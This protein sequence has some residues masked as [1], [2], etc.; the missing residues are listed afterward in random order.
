MND[1]GHKK[2]NPGG[3]RED[4]SDRLTGLPGMR[5]LFDYANALLQENRD[6]PNFRAAFVYI[7][8]I[9]FKHYNGKYGFEQGDELIRETAEILKDCFPKDLVAHSDADHFGLVSTAED[10][11]ERL[12]AAHDRIR[13]IRREDP[14][15]MKAGI[16]FTGGSREPDAASAASDHARTACDII[17]DDASLFVQVYSGQVA[18]Q[19]ARQTYIEEHIDSAIERGDIRVYYQPIVRALTGKLRGFEA[20]ARW[21]DPKYGF[22]SPADFIP[23]LEKSHQ[24][25]KLDYYVVDQTCR[26]LQKEYEA[27]REIVPVSFNLSRLDFILTDPFVE[28]EKIV[29]AHGLQRDM[30][31]VELTESTIIS[32]HDWMKEELG[33]FHEAGYYIW[34]DDFGSGYSALNV[35]KDFQFDTLKIDMEF[36]RDYS[37]KSREI[38]ASM[39]SMAKRIGTHALAEGVETREQADFLRKIGCEM[40]QGYYFGKPAPYDENIINW[41]ERGGGIEPRSMRRYYDAISEIDV[42]TDKPLSLIEYDG[43]Q[44]TVLYNN[45]SLKELLAKLEYRDPDAEEDMVRI[46]DHYVVTRQELFLSKYN[47]A[48]EIGKTREL[49]LVDHDHY[50]HYSITCIAASKGRMAFTFYCTD[51][52]DES[53]DIRK[54][55]SELDGMTRNLL[56]LY[57]N[58]FLHHLDPERDYIETVFQDPYFDRPPGTQYAGSRKHIRGY[59]EK[60]IYP[61]DLP[62]FL[63]D[64]DPAKFVE[65]IQESPTRSLVNQYRVL[66]SNGKYV[67]KVFDYI[68]LPNQQEQV[69]M[70]TV[71][72]SILATKRSLEQV[73][74]VY[75]AEINESAD[76]TDH[77]N[78]YMIGTHE[79]GLTDRDMLISLLSQDRI[80]V[81]WKDRDL[82]YL[83]ANDRFLRTFGLNDPNA[84]IGKTDEEI[85][86]SVLEKNLQDAEHRVLGGAHEYDVVSRRNIG[87]SIHTC[88]CSEVPL[89]GDGQIVGVIGVWFDPEEVRELEEMVKTAETHDLQS[90]LLNG[91]GLL[92]AVFLLNNK[93]AVEGVPVHMFYLNVLSCQQILNE[94]GRET[95]WK[96]VR[97][98]GDALKEELGFHAVIARLTG[99]VFVILVTDSSREQTPE[100]TERSA[101]RAVESIHTVNGNDVTVIVETKRI[102]GLREI[103]QSEALL[104][105]LE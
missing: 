8:I 99:G 82:R 80:S 51:L 89:Y 5:S 76:E 43:R 55:Q 64:N 73:A 7:N 59:G 91:R 19:A 22:L 92:E 44:M 67:W 37:E 97:A 57:D 12:A 66:D 69:M 86:W 26:L 11:E 29:R 71:K 34:M 42:Q 18:E 60:M 45:P 3:R 90:G 48:K 74:S 54:G 53:E 13:A 68:L 23:V 25:H 101:A 6:D 85:G 35:L 16:Y 31:R 39:V 98:I 41:Q 32:N 2:K 52:M 65:R 24:I 56:L 100:E 96:L 93:R 21:Q 14:V 10:T 58:I 62:R 30:L 104:D 38:V 15:E 4:V 27:G 49:R 46:A 47:W 88:F 61:D 87:G 78:S 1:S 94:Y 70:V 84:I 95:F 9:G 81:F 33:R 77:A 83:G 40:L 36:L 28:I 75:Y 103:I 105:S 102:S 72:D 50:I 79:S 63:A 17:H 20:L